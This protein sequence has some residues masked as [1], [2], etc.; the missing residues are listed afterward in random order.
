MKAREVPLRE[1]RG[2]A[3]ADWA[4]GAVVGVPAAVVGW[5]AAVGEAGALADVAVVGA[6]WDG[7]AVGA[8]GWLCPE[9]A[10]ARAVAS[11]IAV[12]ATNRRRVRG[13]W[14]TKR[15]VAL[16]SQY[17]RVWPWAGQIS[18]T[19]LC[20]ALQ[21]MPAVRRKRMSEPVK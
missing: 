12:P 10:A 18:G 21:P 4:V 9:H 19:V 17:V 6:A 8:A 3:G 11:P 14:C 7:A 1:T 20:P 5:A 13:P 2:V 16:S 15:I